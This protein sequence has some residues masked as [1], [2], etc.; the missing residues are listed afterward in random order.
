M[1]T[2]SIIITSIT[3]LL[4]AIGGGAGIIYWKENK[5]L[6]NGEAVGVDISNLQKVIDEY[7]DLLESKGEDIKRYRGLLTEKDTLLE[8]KNSQIFDLQKRCEKLELRV[9]SLL[10]HKCTV[11]GCKRRQPPHVYDIEGNELQAIEDNEESK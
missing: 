7:Q 9:Q 2:L 5:R 6:K 4:A 11:N 3:T 1:D 10:W 8:K